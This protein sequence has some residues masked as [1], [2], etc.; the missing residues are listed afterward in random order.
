MKSEMRPS[1]KN[2]LPIEFEGNL[3]IYVNNSLSFFLKVKQNLHIL[4]FFVSW[5][6][7]EFELGFFLFRKKENWHWYI[8]VMLVDIIIVYSL[9]LLFVLYYTSRQQ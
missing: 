9:C 5:E 2:F 4:L 8:K 1:V 6:K 3:K 7:I